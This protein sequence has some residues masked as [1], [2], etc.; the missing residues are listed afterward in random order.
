[1]DTLEIEGLT[2]A[3]HP[4]GLAFSWGGEEEPQSIVPVQKIAALRAFL[5]AHY[6]AERRLGFRVPL[7]PLPEETKRSFRVTL[8]HEGKRLRVQPVDLSLTG[9]LVELPEEALPDARQVR[10]RLRLAGD[11]VRL[12]AQLVRRDGPLMALHFPSCV[13]NGELDPPEE[14]LGI[15]RTLE[16]DWLRNRVHA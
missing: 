10:A 15:Y 3:A 14:L 6:P 16:L 13:A 2:L 4:R 11:K 1:M 5:D 7:R 9:I 12:E 8:E